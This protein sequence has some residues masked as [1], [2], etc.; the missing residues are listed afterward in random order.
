MNHVDLEDSELVSRLRRLAN[1]GAGPGPCF[2][3]QGMLERHGLRKA[4][5]R[6]RA[7]VAR[8][9]AGALVVAMLGVSAWHLGRPVDRAEG[10]SS[11]QGLTASRPASQPRQF[12]EQRMVRA[13]TWLA[14]AAIEEHIASI[15]DALSDARVN[16][17]HGVDV[18]RLER[19]R[20]ELLDS[21]AHVRYADM[22]AVNF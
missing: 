8:S 4:R 1:A 2:D 15:D 22:V 6:R 19:T 11:V 21:Y 14:L 13:D 5:S 17:P 20:A 18:A 7:V 3:Y 9:V 16:A 10:E 12:P